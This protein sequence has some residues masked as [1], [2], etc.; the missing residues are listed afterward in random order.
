[1]AVLALAGCGDDGGS[2]GQVVQIASTPSPSPTP[3]P[4]PTPSPTPTPAPAVDPY[5]LGTLR[6]SLASDIPADKLAGIRDA[7]E[8]AVAHTN[9]LGAFA[10]TVSV[11][12]GSGTPTADASYQG[13]IRFG[14]AIG[15]RVALHE[16]AHWFGSGSVGEWPGLVTNG[17][18]TGPVA[19]ARI[20]AFDGAQAVLNADRMHF[21][22]YGL[23][24]DSEFAETQRN[25][26]LVSAQRADMRLGVDETAAIAGVRRF[27][28]R[29]G[30]LVLQG[31]TTGATPTEEANAPASAKQQWRV[32]FADGFVTL[33]NAESGLA[34]EGT[35]SGDNVAAVMA[36]ASGA[37]R[38]QWEMMPVGE[39][40]WF[41]LR[42]RATG[43]CLDNIGNLA[44][45]GAVRLWGCGFHPNQQWQLVR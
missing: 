34:I 35:A 44:V 38:Q 33:T 7:M 41:L 24:Y 27:H 12:Y 42:N 16:L 20:R 25:T 19:N 4:T 29:S 18:F 36:P 31:A 21:W 13:Q 14:G 40:G 45:G 8:F 10:G 1:M 28:N 17:R 30:Q 2:G 39:G 6:Y 3:T 9:V 32:T 43:N 11:V 5:V 26:Q 15:R 23:N 37:T 22:P